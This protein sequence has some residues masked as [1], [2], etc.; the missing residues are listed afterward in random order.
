M[1]KGT[2]S[3]GKRN[4][5]NHTICRRCGRKSFNPDKGYC[6]HCGFGRSKKLRKYSW[7]HKAKRR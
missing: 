3:L 1:S 4:K 2:P 7:A 6:A 5:H